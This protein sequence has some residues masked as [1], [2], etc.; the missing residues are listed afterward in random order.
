MQQGCHCSQTQNKLYFISINSYIEIKQ[1]ILENNLED[2][3]QQNI[4]Q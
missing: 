2:Y 3:L 1:H 4:P